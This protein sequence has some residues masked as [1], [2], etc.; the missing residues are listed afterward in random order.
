M[1]TRRFSATNS[2]YCEPPMAAQKA[3]ERDLQL[4]APP[5]TKRHLTARLF[6]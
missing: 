5:L 2:N 3:Q 4:P 6:P 1:V